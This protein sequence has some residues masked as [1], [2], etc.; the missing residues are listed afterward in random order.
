MTQQPTSSQLQ[1]LAQSLESTVSQLIAMAQLIQEIG[2][3]ISRDTQELRLV[4]RQLQEES[5]DEIT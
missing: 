2:G 3:S 4:A 1:V 5:D